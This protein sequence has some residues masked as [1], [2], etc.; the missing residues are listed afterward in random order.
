MRSFLNSMIYLID[1]AAQ[2]EKKQFETIELGILQGNSKILMAFI[3][4]ILDYCQ[5]KH[6]TLRFMIEKF[7]LHEMI[8]EIY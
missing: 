8:M 7:N 5:S 3:N 1:S 6:L 2:S 4:D